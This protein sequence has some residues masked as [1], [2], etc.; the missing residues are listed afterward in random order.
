VDVPGHHTDVRVTRLELEDLMQAPITSFLAA[1]DDTLERYGVPQASVSAVA[2]VGGGARIPLITQRLSEH[3]RAPVVTTS[4]PQLTVAEGAALIAR[5]GRVIEGTTI[6]TPVPRLTAA[7]IAIDA[8]GPVGSLAWSD[9]DGG[10]DELPY[11]GMHTEYP[12]RP[13]DSRPELRFEHKEC[14]GAPPPRRAPLV[15]FGLSAA[16]ALITGAVFVLMQLT[17][18]TTP[19]EAATTVAPSP[20]PAAPVLSPAP[21]AP[22][23]PQ[24]TTVVVEPAQRATP[25]PP[26]PVTQH[27]VAPPATTTTPP[28]PPPPPTTTTPPPTTTSPPTSPPTTTTPPTSPPLS[29][30][31]SPPPSSSP[32][33]L[34]PPPVQ[35]GPGD[36]ESPVVGETAVTKIPPITPTFTLPIAPKIGGEV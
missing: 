11:A 23:V 4:H 7:T 33:S 6:L 22:Q 9:D 13:A 31:S 36:G 16:A 32:S 29:P 26:A 20:A 1:L 18:G 27:P 35:P 25:R 19:V 14:A 5:R 12:Q 28:P 2:T 3:L 10:E 21:P 17:G 15:L 34:E 24:I 8:S 30:P